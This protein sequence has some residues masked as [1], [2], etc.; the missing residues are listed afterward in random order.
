[1]NKR[2]NYNYETPQKYNVLVFYVYLIQKI[3]SL[4]YFLV[5]CKQVPVIFEKLQLSFINIEK[6]Q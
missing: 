4:I 2:K 6:P 5:F 1:M 3:L